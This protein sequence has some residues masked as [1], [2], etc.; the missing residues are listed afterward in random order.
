MSHAIFN[1][2]FSYEA[3]Q[4]SLIDF[5]YIEI[6]K[7]GI[8]KFDGNKHYIATAEVEGDILNYNAPLI[9]YETR[10]NRANMQP[11]KNSV[12]FAKMKNSIKH[13]CI[14]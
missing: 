3:N 5:P 10:E 14:I 8:N 4:I 13:S 9:K 1:K 7:P 12:W 11:I 6:I 2:Y